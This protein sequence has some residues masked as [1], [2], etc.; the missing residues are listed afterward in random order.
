M[1]EQS[2]SL[3]STE[4]LTL[5]LH[6]GFLSYR[7]LFISQIIEKVETRHDNSSQ[8]FIFFY[9]NQPISKIE[10]VGILRRYERRSKKA[11]FHIDDGTGVIVVVKFINDDEI[12]QSVFRE[13]IEIGTLLSVKGQ[14]MKMESNT[15]PYD[16]AI[17]ANLVDVLSD[18][19][20]ELLHWTMTMSS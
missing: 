1:D 17:K 9:E 19:N 8:L 14:L 6:S 2:Q 15:T 3:D 5:G 20:M 11:I 16:Y 10:I 18:P 7:K 4:V 13:N 12:D